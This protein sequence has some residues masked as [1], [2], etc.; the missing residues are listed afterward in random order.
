MIIQYMYVEK[1][2]R[3]TRDWLLAL[4]A[5]WVGTHVRLMVQPAN[6]GWQRA[7]AALHRLSLMAI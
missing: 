6:S 4:L 2:S 3:S 5:G 1:Y 7:A